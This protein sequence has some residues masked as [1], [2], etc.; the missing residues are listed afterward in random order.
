MHFVLVNAGF[1]NVPSVLQKAGL[2]IRNASRFD[3]FAGFEI[4]KR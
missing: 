4:Y 2:Y 1:K 3:I